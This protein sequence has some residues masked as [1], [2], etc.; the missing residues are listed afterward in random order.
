MRTPLEG[1]KTQSHCMLKLVI[2]L[3]E[4]HFKESIGTHQPLSNSPGT[5]YQAQAIV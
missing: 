2:A 1:A 4:R 5:L 3:E